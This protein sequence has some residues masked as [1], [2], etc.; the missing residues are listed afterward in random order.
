MNLIL[1]VNA[2]QTIPINY[3]RNFI[4]ENG[5]I[6]TFK[7][8]K[9]SWPVKVLFYE[10][11]SCARFSQGWS[12]FMKDCGLKVGDSLHFLMV[13]EQNLEF[14]VRITRGRH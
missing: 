5:K 10:H 9:N 8:G 11:Y 7:V 6:T 3:I 13:D 14:E 1:L 2:L 12:K 4:S